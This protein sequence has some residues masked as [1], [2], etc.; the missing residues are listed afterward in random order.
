MAVVAAFWGVWH[1]I[2]GIA[3][4]GLMARTEAAR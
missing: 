1:V 2:T 3:L 4:A